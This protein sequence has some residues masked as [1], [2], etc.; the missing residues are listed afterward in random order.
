MRQEFCYN[1]PR[2]LKNFENYSCY[3]YQ[4]LSFSLPFCLPLYVSLHLSY[5]FL[6]HCPCLLVIADHPLIERE[7][8]VL[9]TTSQIQKIVSAINTCL[10]IF[11]PINDSCFCASDGGIHILVYF[12]SP[13]V[14]NVMWLFI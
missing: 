9:S 5:Q 13:H 6:S 3:Y 4:P 8:P 1:G 7:R 11:C 12:S 2:I 14:L 10:Q